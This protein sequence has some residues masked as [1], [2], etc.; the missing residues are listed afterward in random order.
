MILMYI[1]IY[2]NEG[3]IPNRIGAIEFKK[4]LDEVKEKAIAQGFQE[5]QII[6]KRVENSTS[7]NPGHIV[8]KVIKLNNEVKK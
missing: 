5:M 2:S 3:D 8:N 4:W 1:A 7:A 6:A